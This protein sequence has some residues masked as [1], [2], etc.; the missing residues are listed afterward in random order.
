MKV[1]KDSAI[2][3]LSEFNRIK[4]SSYFSPKSISKFPSSEAF[5]LQNIN[6]NS[7]EIDPNQKLEKSLNHKNKIIDYEKSIDRGNNPLFMEKMKIEDPYKVVGGKNNDVVKAF[8]HL[9]RRAKAATIWDRQLD[10]RKIM[11]GMYT[12]KERRLDEMMEL[13]RLKE[14]KF[15]EEREQILKGYKKE[16]QKAIIDQ[17]YNNDKERNKKR[18]TVEREKILMFK[19]LERLKE[20][21]KQMALRKKL[22]AEAKI[23]ECMDAQKILALNKKKK[24]LEEKEEDLKILKY[25]MEKARKEEEELKEKRRLQEEKERE[26]QKLREKQ[27]KAIDKQAELDALRAK[28]AYEQSEREARIKEKNEMMLKKKKIEEL[29]ASNEKQR[30]D[31]QRQLAEQARQEQQ[32]YQRIVKQQLEEIEK[33]RRLEEDKKKKLYENTKD[34]KVEKY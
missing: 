33:E 32:E 18:E 7:S 29:I 23:K 13:E 5:K 27:E 1:L 28:R 6:M 17:I 19:Q 26:V 25:N 15:I 9:C 30:L 24:L 22:E 16:G 8:D 34:L 31:K 11:E 2:L 14:I 12:N 21:E 4:Q 10:E 20:E 3:S